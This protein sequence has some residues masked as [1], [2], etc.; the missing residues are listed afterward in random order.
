MDWNDLQHFLA[1][2]E[3]GSIAGAAQALGVNHSTVLRRV[4]S[5]E[6]SLGVRLFD[7]LPSGYALTP[8]GHELAESLEGVAERIEAGSRRLQGGDLE[9]RGSVRLTT[10]D[11]LLQGLLNP[12]LAEFS[13]AHPALQLQVVS[14]YGM[15]NLT[16]READVA[17][18]GSNRPP[19]SL[20]GRPVGEIR[21]A[22]Y[23]SRAYLKSL[24]RRRDDAQAW[25][26]VA[27][28]ESLAHLAQMQWLRTHVPDERIAMRLTSLAAMV[29]AVTAG[30]GV[31]LLLCPLADGRRELVQLQPAIEALDTQ[32]WVLTHPD[33]RSVARVKALT[34][35]LVQRL[36]ADPRLLH[37]PAAARAAARP[38]APA[39]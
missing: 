37:R 33:L 9:V 24:G 36:S 6:Q 26:W 22:M 3:R 20:V 38:P 23:A 25:R 13:A 12:L 32:V 17:V 18:R 27:P 28:D 10:T 34:A 11:T 5:L 39:G 15:L 29:E 1:I 21:T 35:F 16:Q 8:A 19:E 7:R 4:A 14:H 2:R 30:V 31:G